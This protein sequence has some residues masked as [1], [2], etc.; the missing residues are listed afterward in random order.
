MT[1]K[2]NVK[3]AGGSKQS[4]HS[5]N[6]NKVE[7]GREENPDGRH[8]SLWIRFK[9]AELAKNPYVNVEQLH[10]RFKH[11]SATEKSVYRDMDS[12]SMTPDRK[13]SG[14]KP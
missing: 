4:D 1:R 12:S 5:G 9:T 7:P 6:R 8:S 3:D 13:I 11:M 10:S 14:R 2:H